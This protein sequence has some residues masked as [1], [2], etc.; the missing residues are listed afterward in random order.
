MSAAWHGGLTRSM[1]TTGGQR[2]DLVFGGNWSH[3]FGPDFGD[4]M[5]DLGTRGIVTG[6]IEI[7]LAASDWYRHGHHL[8]P[9]YNNVIVHVVARADV[10][11]VRREDGVTVPTVVLDI[12]D[13]ALFAIDQELPEIWSTLGH[14]VCAEEVARQEPARLRAAILSLGDQRFSAR[15]ARFEGELTVDPLSTVLLRSL[16]DAFGYSQNREPMQALFA[17][18]VESGFVPR[19]Q[20][21]AGRWS[22]PAVTGMLLGAAGFLPLSPAEAHT[23]G[24]DAGE[25]G[26]IERAWLEHGPG[27]AL[28]ATAWTRSRTRPANHPAV[29]L[30]QLAR[31]LFATRGDP[32]L[33][34]LR[35]VREGGDVAAELRTL[36]GD[37]SRPGL[38]TGRAIAV[39]ASVVLPV[40]MAHG[41]HL[42][43]AELEDATSHA[44]AALPRSEWSRPARRALEQ[45]VGEAPLGKLGERAIQ[46]LLHLDRS[47]CTPRRCFECPVA[48]EVIRDRQR[49]RATQPTSI[50]SVLPT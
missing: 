20:A 50:Q 26:S 32:S 21:D 31:L 11:D 10:P 1:E 3:G 8:D 2:L 18:S 34:L 33:H 48:A 4:A 43:D 37:A 14:S 35:S 13:A 27:N 49:R 9:R 12:P 41:H 40:T 36:T 15:V 23:A 39:A 24:I 7:H 5:I 6:D 30:V 22:I 29:R 45:A 47:L 44:W 28:P 17:L 42:G 16:F 19:L 38:G 46:G 25:V